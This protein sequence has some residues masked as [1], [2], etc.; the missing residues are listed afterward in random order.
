MLNPTCAD[1]VPQ[2]SAHNFG[3]IVIPTRVTHFPPHSIDTDLHSAFIR[4]SSTNQLKGVISTTWYK[5]N[6]VIHIQIRNTDSWA[7]KCAFSREISQLSK[8]QWNA[9]ITYTIGTQHFVH[10]SKVSLTQGLPVF[11]VGMV[12]IIRLLSNNVSTFS[13]LSFAVCW[14]GVLSRG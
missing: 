13:E 2:L 4:G 3:I 7:T 6:T 10:H 11:P 8:I 5:F 12:C 14:Q 1:T 9:S